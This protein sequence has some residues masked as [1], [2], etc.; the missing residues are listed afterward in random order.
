MV[1]FA[2]SQASLG[3]SCLEIQRL[4]MIERALAQ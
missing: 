2:P 1:A 4:A 3:V